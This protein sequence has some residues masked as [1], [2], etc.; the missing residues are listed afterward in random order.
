MVRLKAPIWP[1]AEYANAIL[2]TKE[3]SIQFHLRL[4]GNE[5]PEASCLTSVKEV[6]NIWANGTY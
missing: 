2:F 1:Y 3:A 5:G 6:G 4:L